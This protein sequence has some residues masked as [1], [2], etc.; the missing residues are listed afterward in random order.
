MAPRPPSPGHRSPSDD[1][2]ELVAWGRVA[3]LET[4]GRSSG[5]LHQTPVGFV[6][7]P[8]GSLLVAANDPD[9]DWALN[10]LAE[11][12]CR[13][14]IGER[15]MDCRAEPLAG[16]AHAAAVVAL[17]LRYGTPSERLGGGPAFRLTELG[18]QE[19]P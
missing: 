18:T 11:P 14:V 16:D 4:R 8:D 10:L 7:E 3:L 13:V 9:T 12:R 15:A 17:I 5:R 1:A 2:D 19:G 6:D